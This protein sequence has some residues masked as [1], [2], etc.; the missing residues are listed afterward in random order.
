MKG[1]TNYLKNVTK[2]VAYAAQ[3]IAKEDMIPNVSEFASNNKAFI[4]ST[5]ATIKN[6][7]TAL[8]RSVT[9]IQS[10]RYIRL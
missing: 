5:Y 9:A 7:K 10:L 3:D 4:A 1:I 6:P 2:S 8:K